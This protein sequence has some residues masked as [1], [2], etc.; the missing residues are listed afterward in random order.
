M[1]IYESEIAQLILSISISTISPWSPVAI[2][3][4]NKSTH[5]L[6]SAA[7]YRPPDFRPV[8]SRQAGDIAEP[9]RKAILLELRRRPGESSP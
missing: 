6:T 3:C 9:Q 4:Y 8:Q 7:P 2:T 1:N 5:Q